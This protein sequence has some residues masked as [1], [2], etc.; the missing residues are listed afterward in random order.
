MTAV[1]APVVCRQIARQQPTQRSAQQI[2]A[3]ARI[4]CLRV[5]SNSIRRRKGKIFARLGDFDVHVVVVGTVFFFFPSH[6]L[7]KTTT[8]LPR[9]SL[10]LKLRWLANYC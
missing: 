9:F 2:T 5:N 4:P 6:R 3:N 1:A 7:S 10:S 8:L